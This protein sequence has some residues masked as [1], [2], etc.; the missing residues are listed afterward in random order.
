MRPTVALE[1]EEFHF[2]CGAATGETGWYVYWVDELTFNTEG[3]FYVTVQLTIN[4]RYQDG[5]GF[6]FDKGFTLGGPS[7]IGANGTLAIE[8]SP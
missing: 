7:N 2:R 8:V 5:F 1:D 3:V 6:V 4:R